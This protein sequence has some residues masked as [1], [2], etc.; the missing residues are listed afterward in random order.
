MCILRAFV[1]IDVLRQ[2][3]GRQIDMHTYPEHDEA[4]EIPFIFTQLCQATKGMH[5]KYGREKMGNRRRNVFV[6]HHQFRPLRA[7][8]PHTLNT[9]AQDHQKHGQGV[10]TL[11][12][13]IVPLWHPCATCRGPS[14]L[15]RLRSSCGPIA[16]SSCPAPS[17]PGWESPSPGLVLSVWPDTGMS[18]GVGDLVLIPSGIESCLS[19]LCCLE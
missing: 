14:S 1:G 10:P 15:L 8:T 17:P 3:A 2:V 19:G 4:P 18:S 11:K 5:T 9:Q 12:G 7:C 6:S 16:G 13:R